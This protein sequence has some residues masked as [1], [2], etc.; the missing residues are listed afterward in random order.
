MSIMQ[1]LNISVDVDRLQ[2]FNLNAIPTCNNSNFAWSTN[3]ERPSKSIIPV[4]GLDW[5]SNESLWNENDIYIYI[6]LFSY[7]IFQRKLTWFCIF[8]YRSIFEK[9]L[10]MASLCIAIKVKSLHPIIVKVNLSD[11]WQ[12]L[13]RYINDKLPSRQ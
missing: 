8:C 11:R 3:F 10:V 2:L 5:F 1:L 4:Q 7:N 9:D 12:F 13:D 6:I